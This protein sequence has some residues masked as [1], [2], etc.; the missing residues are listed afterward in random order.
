MN[1]I[2]HGRTAAALLV[3][4]A[5]LNTLGTG[6]ASARQAPSTAAAGPLQENAPRSWYR[7]YDYGVEVDGQSMPDAGLYTLLGKPYML[8]FAPMLDTAYVLTTEPKVV[9]PV[10]R[11]QVTPRSEVE[12]VLAETSFAD[13]A[14][15]PWRQ[16]GD[17]AVVFYAAQRRFKVARVPPLL[18]RTTLEALFG[19]SPVWKRGMEAYRPSPE[20]VASLRQAQEPVTVEVWFGS[21]C[22]HC[23]HVVPMFLKIV[24]AA[25]NPKIQIEYYG[26]PRE[27]GTY[28]PAVEKGIK[29]LPTFIFVKGGKEIGRI[30]GGPS[31]GTLEEEMG[32]ILGVVTTARGG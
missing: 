9:R 11:D 8:V 1:G 26:V 16:D 18:G 15:I 32:R 6:P 12:V 5:V 22:P 19:H 3:G 29:G 10:R 21:W 14:P 7:N 24:Q 13:A 4:A 31:Q 27:F 2:R 28:A 17:T 20:A 25:A 30:R 23:Q